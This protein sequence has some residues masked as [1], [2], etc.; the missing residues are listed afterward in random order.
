MRTDDPIARL[1]QAAPVTAGGFIVTV[2]GDVVVPRGGVLWIGS[3]IELCARIGISETLVRTAVSRLVAAERL[4]GA[5]IGRRSFYRLAEPARVE[6]A[7]AARRLYAPPP[8]SGDW[9]ILFSPDLP[10]TLVRHHRLAPLGE[11]V[12]IAPPSGGVPEGEGLVLRATAL[13][14]GDPRVLGRYWDLAALAEGYRRFLAAFVTLDGDA[15]LAPSEALTLRL[16]LVHH[17]RAVLLKDP[18]LPPEALPDDWPGKAA[19]ALFRRLYQTLTPA[20]EAQIPRILEGEG[21]PL[22]TATSE[23]RACLGALG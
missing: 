8:G 11:G 22:P 13:P 10:E 2:Y 16:L 14:G 4:E 17:Y 15:E 1:M 7:E 12:W 5:R 19:Q 20:A 23:T 3:L 6:F 21:G 18:G 9:T